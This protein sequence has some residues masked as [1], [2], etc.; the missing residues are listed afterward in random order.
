MRKQIDLSSYRISNKL[1]TAIDQHSE[2]EVWDLYQQNNLLKEIGMLEEV[3]M[4][5]EQLKPIDMTFLVG[6]VLMLPLYFIFLPI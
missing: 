6:R 2:E 3:G 4:K 5:Q 1:L